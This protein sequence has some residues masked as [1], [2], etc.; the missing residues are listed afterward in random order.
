MKKYSLLLLPV[1]FLFSCSQNNKT[2]TTAN[3]SDTVATE[4]KN[5]FFPVTAFL[6]GQLFLLDS[7]PV[8]ILEITTIN[9]KQDSAWLSAAVVKPKLAPF[10]LD[11]IDEKNMLPYFKESKFNDQSTEAITLMYDPKKVLPD[12]IAIR[13]WDV[14]IDPD[15]GTI[16]RVYMV[17]QLIENNNPVIQQLT[18]QTGKWAKIVTISND[19]GTTSPTVKEIKWTW[20]LSE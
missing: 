3:A 4:E 18:W 9:N 5:T 11:S 17:K 10:I 8:T 12:S 19:K 6:K 7:L 14:Y 2:N 20:D 15:K 1:L 13:R 16:R